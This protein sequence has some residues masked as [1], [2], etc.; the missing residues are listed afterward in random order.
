MKQLLKA[1]AVEL[2]PEKRFRLM[3]SMACYEA[4]AE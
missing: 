3:G 4:L 2:V 1:H